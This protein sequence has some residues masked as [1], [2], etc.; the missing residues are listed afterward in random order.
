MR[1]EFLCS[2]AFFRTMR[3]DAAEHPLAASFKKWTSRGNNA[4]DRRSFFHYASS[5]V[6]THR[7]QRKINDGGPVFA[8]PISTVID[9]PWDPLV[10]LAALPPRDTAVANHITLFNERSN[11]EIFLYT[12]VTARSFCTPMDLV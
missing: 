6:Q 7:R 1:R 4:L 5:L 9:P 8:E 2:V 11:R 12:D 3:L 10:P